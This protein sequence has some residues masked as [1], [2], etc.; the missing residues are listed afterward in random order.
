MMEVSN[1]INFYCVVDW[2]CRYSAILVFRPHCYSWPVGDS[3]EVL[4]IS[5]RNGR[6]SLSL[7]RVIRPI[8]ANIA[9]LFMSP[10]I[11]HQENTLMD[12]F[13]ESHS[14]LLVI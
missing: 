8:S 6:M 11:K 1:V 7:V 3:A 14:V 12:N 13:S 10:L 5:H 9:V 2:P 4:T